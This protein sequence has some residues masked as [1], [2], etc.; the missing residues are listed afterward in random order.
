MQN[1]EAPKWTIILFG[2]DV[3]TTSYVSDNYNDDG[4]TDPWIRP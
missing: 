4:W 2:T 3:I 1:Y